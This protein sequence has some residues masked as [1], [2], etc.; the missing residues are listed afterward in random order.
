MH[1]QTI[2]HPTSPG[3]RGGVALRYAVSL[4]HDHGARLLILHVVPPGGL[5]DLPP[6][7]PLTA[8]AAEA[9]PQQRRAS[10]EYLISE[11]DAVATILRTAAERGCDLI[12]LGGDPDRS[13]CRWLHGSAHDR[14]VRHAPCPVLIVKEA[15]TPPAART[16][17]PAGHRAPALPVSSV[18]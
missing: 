2:L 8:W 1:L 6:G 16:A 9:G 12:V 3:D 5:T 17:V 13:W 10:L 14:I 4:A 18:G 11:G 7:Q 15:R